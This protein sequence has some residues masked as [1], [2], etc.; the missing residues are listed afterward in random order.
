MIAT[1]LSTHS[2][3]VTA[4]RTIAWFGVIV[5][6]MGFI[7]LYWWPDQVITLGYGLPLFICVVYRSRRLLWSMTAAFAVM[8][9]Y[10]ASI[11]IQLG[12][13]TSDRALL[14]GG[15]HLLNLVVVAI[16]V[17]LIARLLASLDARHADLSRINQALRDRDQ[18]I[19]RQN[20][21]LQ[22]QGEEL[23]QQNEE[24]QQQSEELRQQAEE[25][26]IQSEEL[27]GANIELGK[28]QELMERLLQSVHAVGR[29]G[30]EPSAVC[31]PLLG[32]FSDSA[33]A[34]AV[35]RREGDEMRVI[36]FSGVPQL[37][38][39]SVPVA[40]SFGAFALHHDRVV[41]IS[42]LQL[43]PDIMVPHPLGRR[44]R[45]VL[46]APLRIGGRASGS[47][48]VYAE[49]PRE[50]TQEQFHILEWAA[51]QCSLML[52]ARGLQEQLVTANANLDRIVK[53][54]TGELQEMVHELEHFSYTI[55]HDL[56]APLRAMHGY[57][58]MLTENCGA[59]LNVESREFLRRIE[60]A[61]A[62]RMAT[63]GAV[64]GSNLRTRESR[65]QDERF[66]RT[67]PVNR[68]NRSRRERP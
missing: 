44:I 15:M 61:A 32:L 14:S 1:W 48:E 52:E 25:L 24:I 57:A 17:H 64:S 66:F 18:E 30:P 35:F 50:W 5:T 45:S 63:A 9:F 13:L 12:L 37:D 4:V 31:G 55:T 59:D 28:R 39:E 3:R 6:G 23:A 16:A 68:A 65:D 67:A 2:W 26:Q 36:T 38:R 51:G 19:S 54:R 49:S 21:E 8:V 60:T 56:R 33:V 34:L 53:A 62:H 20:E 58:G 10:K 46:A 43:R 41:A 7:R 42:D 11:L 40:K 29:A 22:A 47:I 27:R